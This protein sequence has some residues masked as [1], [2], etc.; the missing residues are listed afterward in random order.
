MVQYHQ[1]T[2]QTKQTST[3]NNRFQRPRRPQTTATARPHDA[4]TLPLQSI[5]CCNP[6]HHRAPAASLHRSRRR[7]NALPPPPMLLSSSSCSQQGTNAH[8]PGQQPARHASTDT[9]PSHAAVA[10]NA[11]ETKTLAQQ[12]RSVHRSPRCLTQQNVVWK[13]KT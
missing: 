10:P 8:K 13:Q 4:S 9:H 5:Y 6:C 2:N 12:G 3:P 7:S 11:A 1:T